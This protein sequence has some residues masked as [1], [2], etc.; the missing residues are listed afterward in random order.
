MLAILKLL[1]FLSMLFDN[2][3][4]Q[5]EQI[6]GLHE[7]LCDFADNLLVL[8]FCISGISLYGFTYI[9][10]YLDLGKQ[11]NISQCDLP[12]SQLLTHLFP[13]L[14]SL[15]SRL[16]YKHCLWHELKYSM[17]YLQQGVRHE[18]PWFVDI[19]FSYT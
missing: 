2:Y 8:R 15:V 1:V 11:E 16:D 17:E 4:N 9:P 13:F 5:Y 14:I 10:R 6:S 19:G 7:P 3:E 12:S 18:M